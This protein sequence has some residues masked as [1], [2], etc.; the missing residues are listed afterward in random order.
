MRSSPLVIL[1]PALG[2]LVGAVPM[3]GD[4]KRLNEQA[5][6]RAGACG[7][8]MDCNELWLSCNLK[9]LMA[10]RWFNREQCKLGSSTVLCCPQFSML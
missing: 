3:G 5:C 6:A 1:A 8:H 9:L 7:H 2:T 10:G 4:L